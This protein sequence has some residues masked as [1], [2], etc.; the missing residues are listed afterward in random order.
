[1][2]QESRIEE[3]TPIDTITRGWRVGVMTGGRQ[4]GGSELNMLDL[5]DYLH[6]RIGGW[7]DV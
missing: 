3:G 1:M 6:S 4:I 7:C 5:A 2:K